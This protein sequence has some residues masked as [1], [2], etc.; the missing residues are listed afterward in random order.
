MTPCLHLSKRQGNTTT[1]WLFLGPTALLNFCNRWV[2]AN[3]V[4][5]FL[6]AVGD[7]ALCR[8]KER[9]HRIAMVPMRCLRVER[10]QVRGMCQ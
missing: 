10:S 1:S 4:K 2:G 5:L 9:D 7:A 6:D 8:L 3:T